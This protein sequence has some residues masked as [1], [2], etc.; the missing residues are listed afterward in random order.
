MHQK[1]NFETSSSIIKSIPIICAACITDTACRVPTGE[2]R[3][4]KGINK[5]CGEL[6]NDGF[7]ED[8]ANVV[9]TRHAVS[10]N[11]KINTDNW[12]GMYYGHG[13]PCPYGCGA[14]SKRN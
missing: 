3:T 14:N 5:Q 13:V 8:G 6:E 1:L 10:V 7:I 2:E 9:G 11:N 4:A 12:R